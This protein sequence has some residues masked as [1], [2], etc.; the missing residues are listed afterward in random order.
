MNEQNYMDLE[1]TYGAMNY[2]PLPVVLERGKG[3]WVWDTEG[4]KYMDMLSSY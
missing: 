4:N 3:V 1:N 2:N